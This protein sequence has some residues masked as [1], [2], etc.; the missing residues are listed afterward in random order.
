MGNERFLLIDDD[1]TFAT[2]LARSLRRR[3]LDVVTADG[4]VQAR[5]YCSHECYQYA[6]VDLRMDDENGLTLIPA[7]R[8]SNPD[9]RI[10]VLTGYASIATAVDAGK[11]GADNYLPKPANASEILRALGHQPTAPQSKAGGEPMSIRRHEWE[12]I[13]RVLAHNGGNISATARELGMHRRTLQRKLE[14]HP[15]R[16]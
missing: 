3:G 10:L 2:T 8:G 14:K 9:M 7:L 1:E 15:V 13:Q 6:T 12:T 11:R 4:G 5:A 16:R